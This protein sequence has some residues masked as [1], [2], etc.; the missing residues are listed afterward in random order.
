MDSGHPW[1]DG[2]LLQQILLLIIVPILLAIRT[3][4]LFL[5]LLL[6]AP[7]LMVL[8]HILAICL[9]MGQFNGIGNGK[10]RMANVWE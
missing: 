9:P 6:L 1:E 3:V 10:R 7:L 5:F 4:A 8:L 2:R